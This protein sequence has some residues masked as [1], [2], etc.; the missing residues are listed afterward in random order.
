M[1]FIEEN[2]GVKKE[3]ESEQESKREIPPSCETCVF[4][5]FNNNNN[6]KTIERGTHTVNTVRTHWVRGNGLHC[7]KWY[8]LSQR[9]NTQKPFKY[10]ISTTTTATAAEKS[11]YPRHGWSFRFDKEWRLKW[12][13]FSLSLPF[14]HFTA[15]SSL[16]EF[17]HKLCGFVCV[18][19]GWWKSQ[20]S[21]TKMVNQSVPTTQNIKWNVVINE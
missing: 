5:S 7:W 14:V 8:V 15:M 18:W 21:N 6:K 12:F 3:A 13:F 16:I 10:P 1:E 4:F 17:A 20:L 9:L 11:V 19:Q 2:Y